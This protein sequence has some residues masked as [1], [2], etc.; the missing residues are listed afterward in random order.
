MPFGRIFSEKT[1]INERLPMSGLCGVVSKTNCT[2]SLLFGTDY[3]SHLGSELAGMAVFGEGFRKKIRDIS[4]GQF[5]SKF[6][7]AFET[8][9]GHMGV[10][11]ISDKDAQ[12]LL[13]RSKHGAYSLAYAGLIENKNEIVEK[14]FKRGAVFT[15]T[16]GSG[17]NAVELLA[18]IIEIGNDLV[19][20]I[21]G[22]YDMIQGSATMLVLTPQ[23]IIAA[24]DRLGRTPLTLGEKEDGYMVATESGAFMN[25]DYKPIKD[26]AP[27]EVI[28][29]K[30]DGYEVL[31][32]PR[33]EQQICAF[34]WVYTGYPASSYE[35]ISVER[36]RESCGAALAR[37][38]SIE[39]DLV[40]GVP[41]SGTGH[42]VGYAMESG[43]PFRRA[44]VKI[45]CR[46]RQK[47]H[48]AFAENSGPCGQNEAIGRP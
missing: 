16:T 15:E 29:I 9:K 22:V 38:D 36:V 19:D 40:S 39:A 34:L 18:K 26:L 43:I 27:G 37:R 24:R 3:H 47:L 5:K 14:L 4:Q 23:G 11:V 13:I 44:L 45:L 10:G 42:A 2:E 17:I 8:M 33:E 25:L 1:N 32:Q 30:P 46:L 35:N 12:P 21:T 41:D 7:D 6:G 48:S 28:L 31:V 20:G